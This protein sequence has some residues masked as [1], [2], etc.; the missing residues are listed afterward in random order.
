MKTKKISP[1]HAEELAE[2]I[3]FPLT[4]IPSQKK[5][6]AEQLAIARKKSQEGS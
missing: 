6:A 3:V 1:T 5:E 2:A 4:L